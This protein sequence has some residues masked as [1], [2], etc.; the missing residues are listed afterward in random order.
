MKQ[1]KVKTPYENYGL[2][3]SAEQGGQFVDFNQAY[4]EAPT[5][6]PKK[7]IIIKRKKK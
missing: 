7:R 5:K 6:V 3:P 1:R 2:P 4:K